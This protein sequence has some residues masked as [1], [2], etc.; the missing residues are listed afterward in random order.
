MINL[1]EAITL[2]GFLKKMKKLK[3]ENLYF[4]SWSWKKNVS[5][6]KNRICCFPSFVFQFEKNLKFSLLFRRGYLF[7]RLD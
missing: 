7:F 1:F 6:V 5:E 2:E 4:K 3:T